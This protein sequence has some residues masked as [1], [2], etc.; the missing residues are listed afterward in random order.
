MISNTKMAVV[1]ISK[2]EAT[3]ATLSQIL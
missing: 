3:L 2:V 1:L